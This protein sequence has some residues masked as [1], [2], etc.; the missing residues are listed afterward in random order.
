M[1]YG[2]SVTVFYVGET[3]A[4]V[5]SFLRSLTDGKTI[6]VS[7]VNGSNPWWY[8]YNITSNA[9]GGGVTSLGVLFVAGKDNIGFSY[10]T[11]GN[12]VCISINNA[13]GQSG[14][15]GTSG[16]AG[17]SGTS[18]SSGS[19]GSSGTSGSS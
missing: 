19:S 15:S 7:G 6:T 2:P 8:Q 9:F 16:S 13:I 12:T 3:D 10:T 17:T 14:S 5:T 4:E 1:T 11:T 18:G